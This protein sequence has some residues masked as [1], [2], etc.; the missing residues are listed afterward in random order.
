MSKIKALVIDDDKDILTAARLYLNRN[1]ILTDTT[2]TPEAIPDFM[3]KEN[4]DV[5]LLDLNFTPGDR[6][7]TEGLKWLKRII[8]ADPN[9]AVIVITAF[10]GVDLAVKALKA[11]AAD[12]IEKPWH[13]EKLLAAIRTMA[14]L[15]SSRNEVKRLESLTKVLNDQM[16]N[17]FHELIGRSAGMMKI[18]SIIKKLAD[19]DA[20]V[21]I[22]GENGTGKELVA[23]A[24]YRTSKRS[25]RV[26]VPI[27][28]GAVPESLMESELFGHEAG[29]FT[30]AKKQRIG[31]FESANNGTIFL[32]EIGN[33]PMSAAAKLLRVLESRQISRI[34]QSAPV[35]LDIRLICATNKDLRGLIDRNLFREDLLYRINTIEINL[36]PL[37][38]REGDIPIL[39]KHFLS[40]Y[41]RKYNHPEKT[42]TQGAAAKL[43]K[44]HW[45]GNIRELR[46]AIERAVILSE[47]D[48]IGEDD[49]ILDQHNGSKDVILSCNYRLDRI[50]KEVILRVINKE[51]NNLSRIA[52][53]LGIS[54][55]TLYRRLE[56]HDIRL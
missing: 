23:R 18:F 16:D 17:S 31:Y 37:R 5:I 44:H 3:G 46:H 45:P 29:A 10:S 42:I 12:F 7:G 38:E 27:D 25:D 51:G 24:I 21:L 47:S 53:T 19:T 40:L 49:F 13:N 6:S 36:P 8:A 11:G 20:N 15:R 55:Q 34:G 9:A 35:P 14:D 26:F 39:T 22:G 2:P 1:G 30:D 33:I 28:L 41:K 43:E 56:K 32:D 52:E 4:Y 50:E 54:R 48:T